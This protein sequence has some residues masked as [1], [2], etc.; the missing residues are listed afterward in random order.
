MITLL[1]SSFTFMVSI[2]ISMSH[3]SQICT[4]NYAHTPK[5]QIHTSYTVPLRC[6]TVTADLQKHTI[7]F[8]TQ[9]QVLFYNFPVF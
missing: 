2:I 8:P 7:T 4:F 9:K 5:F 1:Q 3:N 6:L